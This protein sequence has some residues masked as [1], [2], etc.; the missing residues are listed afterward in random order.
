MIVSGEHRRVNGETSIWTDNPQVRA[1]EIGLFRAQTTIE[2]GGSFV[3]ASV[4]LAIEDQQQLQR[5]INWQSACRQR[6]GGY[7][8]SGRWPDP[9]DCQQ[10]GGVMLAGW[11]GRYGWIGETAD[12]ILSEARR[13]RQEELAAAMTRLL[14]GLVDDYQGGGSDLGQLL[15][16]AMA[17]QRLRQRWLAVFDDKPRADYLTDWFR[18]VMSRHQPPG[19]PR[20][21]PA[22]EFPAG[23]MPA[24]DWPPADKSSV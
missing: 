11:F 23:L 6:A 15:H 7:F 2:A 8:Q 5:Y 19:W 21:L 18:A 1:V 9:G 4:H 24:R 14:D 17:R 16:G 22:P 20:C 13:I 10:A 3:D 12:R